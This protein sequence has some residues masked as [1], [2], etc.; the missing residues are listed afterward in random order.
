MIDAMFHSYKELLVRFEILPTSLIKRVDN[1]VGQ[2]TL[3]LS[4]AARGKLHNGVVKTHTGDLYA[5]IERG[6]YVKKT[7]WGIVGSVGASGASKKEAIIAGA[8]EYGSTHPAKVEESLKAAALRFKI[9]GKFAFAGTVHI[10]A[11]HIPAHSF[12]RSALRELDSE[13]VSS[14]ARAAQISDGTP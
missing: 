9:G 2:L 7:P 12:L 3:K 11:M 10:P 13:V 6:T 5:A 8:V 14:I 4:R 1:T